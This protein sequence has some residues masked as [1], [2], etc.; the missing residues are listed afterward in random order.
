MIGR[1]WS[2]RC[3]RIATR[4]GLSF[5]TK[6]TEAPI[7]GCVSLHSRQDE[8]SGLVSMLQ[9]RVLAYG[10]PAQGSKRGAGRS[11]RGPHGG[12][13]GN[14]GRAPGTADGGRAAR[15]VRGALKPRGGATLNFDP[16]SA[17][18]GA[19]DPDYEPE[20][21]VVGDAEEARGR[22]ERA[23]EG[24]PGGGEAQAG[25]QREERPREV[26]AGRR[27]ICKDREIWEDFAAAQAPNPKQQAAERLRLL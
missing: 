26:E 20:K 19:R 25:A 21:G 18:R 9:T 24:A 7:L 13:P 3:R 2:T 15:T 17:T 23:G 14:E 6:C 10:V 1:P 16:H 27:D 5:S 12:T 22:A 8:G 4:W 11:G